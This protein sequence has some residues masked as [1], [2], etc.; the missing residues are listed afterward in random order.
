MNYRNKINQIKVVLGLDIKLASAKLQSGAAVEA[1]AFEPGYPLFIVNE[2]GTKSPAPAGTHILDDGSNVEV[3]EQGNIVEISKG[4]TPAEEVEAAAETPAKMVPASQ[5]PD[6]Q[7]KAQQAVD[8]TLAKVVMAMEE[9]SA[10]LAKM[11]TKM[12]EMESKFEKFAKAPGA[13]K[14][15]KVTNQ[16]EEAID[17]LEAKIALLQELKKEN[18]FTQKF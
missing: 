11:K 1:E 15:P 8:T 10:E 3:D 5:T 18:F 2:D 17:P 13:T 16:T 4:E 12:T 9:L 14:F 7:A 6:E